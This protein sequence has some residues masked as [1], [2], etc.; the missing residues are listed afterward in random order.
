VRLRAKISAFRRQNALDHAKN[1][2][3]TAGKEGS[4]GTFFF[5][6]T[7]DLNGLWRLFL[8]TPLPAEAGDACGIPRNAYESVSR[9]AAV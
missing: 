7:S 6:E 8:P 3:K 9:F 4:A 5:H 2:G 1:P